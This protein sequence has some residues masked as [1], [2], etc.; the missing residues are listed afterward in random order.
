MKVYVVVYFDDRRELKGGEFPVKVKV[1]FNRE[2]RYYP[3]GFSFT[4]ELWEKINKG[5]RRKET[6]KAWDEIQAMQ[7]RYKA[8]ADKLG[9]GFKFDDFEVAIS[10][11]RS[12]DGSGLVSYLL[13]IS[14]EFRSI[15]SPSTAGQY[16]NAANA[17]KKQSGKEDLPFRDCNP[18]FL[19]R[20]QAETDLSPASFS[21]YC[22]AVRAAFNRAMQEKK[23]NPS[24]YPFGR[25]RFTIPAP[26][27]N[28][29]ALTKEERQKVLNYPAETPGEIWA[30]DM[31]TFSYL[32][33]G[34]N[35]KDIFSLRWDQIAGGSFEY[36]RAKTKGKAQTQRVVLTP[37]ML[38]IIERHGNRANKS[39]RVF[40]VIPKGLTPDQEM[41]R[42]NNEIKHINNHLAAIGEKLGLGKITTQAA[43]H[44]VFSG[45]VE[46]GFSLEEVRETAGHSSI[47]VT[48]NYVKSLNRNLAAD[49][50]DFLERDML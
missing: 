38:K 34:M 16:L 10:R 1:T 13:E 7:A 35:M 22:R 24:L 41:K 29:R 36:I 31:F 45:M 40:D 20:W 49:V 39:G 48:Q 2:R 4:P 12:G 33:K 25:G 44:S 18:A 11:K 37:T 23:V 28:K 17:I 8:E 43:R 50:A 32:S 6:K 21:I 3:T 42:K 30:R 27:A 9:E 15:G 5:E 47:A 46:D 26:T 19:K 14:D